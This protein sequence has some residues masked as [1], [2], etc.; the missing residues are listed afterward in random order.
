MYQCRQLNH[1]N[2]R[3]T[4]FGGECVI[5]LY[6]YVIYNTLTS[7]SCVERQWTDMIS[8]ADTV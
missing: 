2:I 5:I 7:K 8:S 1:Y 4:E 3:N 6:V